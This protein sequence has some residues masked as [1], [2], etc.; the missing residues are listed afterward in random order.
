MAF[1]ALAPIFT[2]L[3]TAVSA[4]GTYQQMSSQAD[5]ADYN[6]SVAEAEAKQKEL[7]TRES[8]KRQRK[9]NERFKNTQRAA[10]AKAGITGTGTP[11]AVMSQTAADLE[12]A[13]LDT[14]YQG[15]SQ[16]RQLKQN[17]AVNKMQSKSLNSAK[18]WAVGSS[19]LDGGNQLARMKL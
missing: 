7:E 4:Y 6:A 9:E 11:L 10:Y 14:S 18:P 19:I 12:L 1:A 3:G 5:M 17:A 8:V 16:V 15:Q 2:V 13:A